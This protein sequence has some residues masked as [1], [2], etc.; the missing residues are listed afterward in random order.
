MKYKNNIRKCKNRKEKHKEEIKEIY[1]FQIEIIIKQ[2][3]R[4][5]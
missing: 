5:N 1:I 2:N 3:K 4:K